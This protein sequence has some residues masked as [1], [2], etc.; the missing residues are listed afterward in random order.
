MALSIADTQN[1]GIVRIIV[2]DAQIDPALKLL[3][4]AGFMAKVNNVICSVVE[5]RPLGLNELLVK[6]HEIGVSVEYM[7]SVLRS[8]GEN[9]LIIV[10]LSEQDEAVHK[11]AAAGVRVVSQ[12]EI[13]KLKETLKGT[14]TEAIK[15]QTEAVTKA[16]HAV[17]EKLYQ[18]AQ[19]QQGAAQ[20]SAE[21][22]GN[23]DNVVDADYTQVD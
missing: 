20:A 5:D 22:T 8:T 23:D 13:D 2:S 14:D 3:R 16:F 1:F 21:P 6:I 11:L 19:A 4:E 17:S 7:Y 12:A 15:A 9:A 10:R 18:A